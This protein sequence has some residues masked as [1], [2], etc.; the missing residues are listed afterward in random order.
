[1]LLAGDI[2]ATKTNLAVFTNRDEIYIPLVEA[3]FPSAQYASLGAIVQ[4][5]LT[6]HPLPIQRACF[7]VAGPVIDGQA[8]VTNL[9]WEIDA[10]QLQKQFNLVSVHL[11]NDLTSIANALPVLRP[12]DL[13]TLHKGQPLAGGSLAVI[14]PGTGLGEAFLTWDGQ[15][16]RAYPS[17]GGHT[18]FAPTNDWQIRLLQYLQKGLGFDHVSYEAVCSGLGIPHIYEFVKS[19]YFADEP[20]WLAEQLAATA[21]PTPVIVNA[22]LDLTRPCAICAATLDTFVDIL[23]AETGNL[24]LKVLATGGV[25]LGGGIPPRILAWLQRGKFMEAFF[26]KGRLSS[27]LQTMPVYV[28]LNPKSAILGAATYGFSMA[29]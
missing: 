19:S 27:V 26:H 5:F 17:E 12:N 21:D 11:L 4:T 22:A 7:G 10:Q 14:A 13:Y 3:T 16:Y 23:G 20:P 6:Q 8:M 28:I 29:D 25:Y 2:G 9:H 24:A 15:R 18:D 1:M